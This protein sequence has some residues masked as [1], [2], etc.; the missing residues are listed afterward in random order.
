M[1]KSKFSFFLLLVTIMGCTTTYNSRLI[2]RI[3][4]GMPKQEVISIMGE[5]ESVSA[6]NGVEYLTYSLYPPPPYYTITEKNTYY[7][8]I[9]N[10]IVD[11]YGRIGDFDST[12]DPG[13]R[14]KQD[15]TIER[16]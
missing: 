15:V 14:V 1:K 7:V 2:N 10:G 8:R 16:K 5:P 11:S 9:I 6:T 3:S 4:L 12:K 13:V